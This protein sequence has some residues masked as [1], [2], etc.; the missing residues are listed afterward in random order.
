MADLV[1]HGARLSREVLDALVGETVELTRSLTARG[2]TLGGHTRRLL[3]GCGCCEIPP[4]CWMPQQLGNITSYVCPGATASLRLRITNGSVVQREV[5]VAASG[6]QV[7]IEPG[8]ITLA[9]FGEG[10]VTATFTA[11]ASQTSEPQHAQLWVHGCRDHVLRWTVEVSER[12]CSCSHEIEI[13]DCPD[14][15]HH[16]YDHFYCERTCPGSTVVSHG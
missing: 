14:L 4:P 12:G 10:T 6:P 1:D 3:G 15:V 16:W 5:T 7:A 2:T 13:E 11:A 8:S 9:P